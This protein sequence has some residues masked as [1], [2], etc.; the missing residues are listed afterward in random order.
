[1][2]RNSDAQVFDENLMFIENKELIKCFNHFKKRYEQRFSESNL[3][4]KAFWIEWICILRGKMVM[5]DYSG[6]M[7]RMIGNYFKDEKHYKVI[8]TKIKKYNIYVPV[9]IYEVEHKATHKMYLKIL[10]N[11]RNEKY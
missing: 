7:V 6:R 11:K 10:E 2:G 8:Y 1:M 5:Y 3:T 4:Y 9:T